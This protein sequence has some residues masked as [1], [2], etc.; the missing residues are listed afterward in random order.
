[1]VPR[2]RLEDYY[3]ELYSKIG[4][5]VVDNKKGESPDLLAVKYLID[6]YEEIS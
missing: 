5:D 4:K 6:N 3:W 2:S 1:L